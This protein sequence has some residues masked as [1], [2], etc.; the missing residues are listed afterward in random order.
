MEH[1]R[2]VSRSVAAVLILALVV[3]G[4]VRSVG[5]QNTSFGTGA[6]AHNTT[7]TDNSA[8]G[9]DALF[10]NIT[11]SNNTAIG[12]NALVGNIGS[13]NTATGGNALANNSSGFLNTATGA[14]AL[15]SNTGC[16][17]NTATGFNALLKNKLRLGQN[18]GVVRGI[19]LANS[20]EEALEHAQRHTGWVWDHTFAHFG[21]YEAFRFAGEEGPV[22]KPGEN[23]VERLAKADYAL[24]GTPDQVKRKLATIMEKTQAEYLVWLGDQG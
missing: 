19:W 9:F 12:A 24:L 20:Y 2:H 14:N 3:T 8:F 10:E 11:T 17:A 4:T 7:G 15:Q 18:V 6:L 22:P 1:P 16:A 13:D 21:F 23:A 5:A